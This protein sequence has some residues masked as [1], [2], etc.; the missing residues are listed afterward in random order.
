MPEEASTGCADDDHDL[1]G[2][3]ERV[4]WVDDDG[5]SGDDDGDDVGGDDDG[6]DD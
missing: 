3:C 6:G 5:G 4:V 1:S 2:S